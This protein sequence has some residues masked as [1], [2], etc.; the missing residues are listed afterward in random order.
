MCNR[1]SE[2]S[3]RDPRNDEQ[4]RF[5]PF[6]RQ[7]TGREVAYAAPFLISNK[8]SYVNAHTPFLDAGHM[9]GIVRT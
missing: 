2:L 9:A 6:A 3:L 7:G 4:G 1:T 8:S 5:A